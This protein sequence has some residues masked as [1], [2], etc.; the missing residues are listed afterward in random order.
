[1]F[2]KEGIDI[3]HTG[4]STKSLGYK[5]G[6]FSINPKSIKTVPKLGKKE[7]EG[8]CQDY[9]QAEKSFFFIGA[10]VSKFFFGRF[11]RIYVH[12]LNWVIF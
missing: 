1:M 12:L 11:L 2:L 9:I 8:I 5:A 3:T 10:D 6:L 4:D 7:A